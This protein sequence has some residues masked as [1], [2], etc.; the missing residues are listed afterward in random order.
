ML[1][2]VVLLRTTSF[3]EKSN[4]KNMNKVMMGALPETD[5]G[6][7][8]NADGSE[9][10]MTRYTA[11]NATSSFDSTGTQT[12]LYSPA[13]TGDFAPPPADAENKPEDSPV[14]GGQGESP[15]GEGTDQKEDTPKDDENGDAGNGTKLSPLVLLGGAA[16]IY[17][18][19]FRKKS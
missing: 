5:G 17:F 11:S 1:P 10:R 3:S 7:R 19:F 14:D 4:S 9:G 13:P 8:D 6:Y 2:L 18:L 15:T 12:K 16:L